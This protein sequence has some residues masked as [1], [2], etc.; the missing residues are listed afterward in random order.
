MSTDLAAEL[1]PHIPA[2]RRYAR[3][4]TRH[5]DAADDLVQDCLERALSRW[6]LH[7][8]DR[9]TRAWL[10]AITR[11]IF[12]NGI[13]G[14]GRKGPHV[15]YDDGGGHMSVDVGADRTLM[16]RDALA[17]LQGMAEED[18]S[19]LLLVGVE[20]L[21]YREAAAVFGVPEGTIMSRLSRARA[22]LRSL[23]EGGGR[24]ALRRVK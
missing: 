16:G 7:R 5:P 20:D 10:F 19:L 21:S 17:I 9:S 6:H 1:E 14:S 22:R 24:I 15:E 12:L 13:R 8:R 18:R 3:S 2:L 23:V 4:L 11:N